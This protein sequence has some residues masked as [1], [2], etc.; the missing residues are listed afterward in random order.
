MRMLC[1][2][3]PWGDRSLGGGAIRGCLEDG[4][5]RVRAAWRCVNGIVRVSAL[6]GNGTG[7]ESTAVEQLEKRMVSMQT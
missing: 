4:I 7:Y 6:V 1:K 3:K 2:A 5:S